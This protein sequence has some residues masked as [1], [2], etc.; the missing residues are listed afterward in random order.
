[1][2]LSQFWEMVHWSGVQSGRQPGQQ[3]QLREATAA[4]G[5]ATDELVADGQTQAAYD[6]LRSLGKVLSGPLRPLDVVVTQVDGDT[7]PSIAFTDPGSSDEF[8]V[9]RALVSDADD[10]SSYSEVARGALSPLADA[11]WADVTA[12]AYRVV[13]YDTGGGLVSVASDTTLYTTL[14]PV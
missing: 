10:W 3:I 14:A 1:M 7:A 8:A 6:L 4:L 2:T 11:T 9:F 5:S 12:Y 13:A